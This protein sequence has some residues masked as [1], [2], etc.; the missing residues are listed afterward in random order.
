MVRDNFP[1]NSEQ[2][3][4]KPLLFNLKITDDFEIEDWLQNI[5]PKNNDDFY[6]EHFPGTNVLRI[7]KEPDTESNNSEMVQNSLNIK[8]KD[9]IDVPL[10]FV[11][12][13]TTESEIKNWI[14]KKYTS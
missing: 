4:D 12:N 5:L 1:F 11:L 14:E 2:Q 9:F 10:F 8:I 3:I 6:I 7:R 13:Q